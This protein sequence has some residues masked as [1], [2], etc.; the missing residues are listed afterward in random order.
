MSISSW[1]RMWQWYTY[2]Q[3]KLTTWLT[4]SIGSPSGL[5]ANTGIPAASWAVV[6]CR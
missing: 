6:F 3:P 4:T 1:L 2:S 5:N